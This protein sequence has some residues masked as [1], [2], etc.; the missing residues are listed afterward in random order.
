MDSHLIDLVIGNAEH[1]KNA[2]GRC[3]SFPV[4]IAYPALRSDAKKELS[5]PALDARA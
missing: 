2:S 5:S 4:P 1:R 3:S